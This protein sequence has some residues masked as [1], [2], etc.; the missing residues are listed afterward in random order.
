V[1]AKDFIVIDFGVAW[2]KAFHFIETDDDSRRELII[3]SQAIV[4]TSVPD[5]EISYKAVLQSFED[6]KK[7]KVILCS[8]FCKKEALEAFS[9]NKFVESDE[10]QRTL[11]SFF[12]R[13]QYDV[14][15]LEGGA[16]NWLQNF[17]PTRVS[18]LTGNRITEIEIENYLGNKRRFLFT[19]ASEND[20]I[21]IEQA[22]L[23]NYLL[24][25][26]LAQGEKNTLVIATGGMLSHS[27]NRKLVLEIIV[28]RL[29]QPFCQILLDTTGVLP[30]FGALLS[31]ETDKKEIVK[32]PSLLSLAAL[33][34][35][36]GP[37]SVKLD[38]GF[39]QEQKI[40]VGVDEL[41]LLPAEKDKDVVVTS[42]NKQNLKA[43]LTV[44]E[45][46]VVVDARIKPLDL[47]AKSDLAK[48]KIKKWREALTI[49]KA[50]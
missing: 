2:T 11:T 36:G 40:H 48:E 9:T 32:V 3:K 26:G 30:S 7:A 35:L 24:T 42:I 14:L 21:D 27:K 31:V 18:T 49:S 22:Y 19:V 13:S 50:L 28:D 20:D 8:S 29:T 6:A 16:S 25:R 41:V 33:I 15:F 5:L 47:I 39:S 17:E 44:G 45:V 10:V 43:Q 37:S 4:P 38:F 1:S 12:A 46:G 34:N 23:K